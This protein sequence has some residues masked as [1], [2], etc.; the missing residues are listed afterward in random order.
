MGAVMSHMS[1]RVHKVCLF[2]APPVLRDIDGRSLTHEEAK[3]LILMKYEVPEEIRRQRRRRKNLG[4]YGLQKKLREML[5]PRTHEAAV[6][7][8]SG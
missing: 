2:E 7:P 5:I 4:N 6:A 3:K 1:A 8:Q